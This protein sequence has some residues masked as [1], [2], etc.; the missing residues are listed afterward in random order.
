[1][2]ARVDS[3][4]T[5]YQ[6]DLEAALARWPD[7]PASWQGI[8]R[9]WGNVVA[10]YPTGALAPGNPRMA[11]L[12]RRL[13]SS[14]GGAGL[15]TYGGRDSLHGYLGAD[16]GVWAMLAGFRAAADSVLT[17]ALYWRSASGGAGEIF[18]RTGDYGRNLPPHPTS[19]A[20]L[21]SLLRNAVIED[22]SDTLRLTLG[23]RGTW[24][25]NGLITNAPTRWGAIDLEFTRRDDYAA[26][27]WTAVPVWTALTLPPGTR[28]AEPLAAPLRPGT[29]ADVVMA[30][31]NTN[32]ARVRVTSAGDPT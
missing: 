2:A 31:P 22:G 9:D 10:C 8:G 25:R 6:R 27:K 3:S 15:C 29:R 7:V 14:A 19:A 28:L 12:A 30:P 32:T 23:A 17:A 20:A 18:A 16:L 5:A 13:W 21:V 4:R 1:M 11:S 26:W 24:W